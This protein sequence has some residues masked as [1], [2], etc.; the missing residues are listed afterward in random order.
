MP[1]CRALGLYS[2]AG[3]AAKFGSAGSTGARR[4]ARSGARLILTGDLWPAGRLLS[5]GLVTDVVPA[6]D[7]MPRALELAAQIVAYDP[8]AVGNCLALFDQSREL[9]I[10][11][12][13]VRGREAGM[14][15]L[16]SPAT[17][18]GIQGFTN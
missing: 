3:G 8:G 17:R 1:R 13:L 11:E 14:A 5:L 2:V 6:P 18:A 4:P 16:G 15:T 7:V 10:G 12:A 9:I